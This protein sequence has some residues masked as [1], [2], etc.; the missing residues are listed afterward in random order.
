LNDDYFLFVLVKNHFTENGDHVTLIRADR[1]GILHDNFAQ[2]RY[3]NSQ[4]YSRYNHW[5]K[6]LSIHNRAMDTS[7]QT[8]GIRR[9]TDTSIGKHPVGTREEIDTRDTGS[10]QQ[11]LGDHDD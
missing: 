4:T 5:R 3:N 10:L 6:I 9:F 8:I 7:G 2:H 11:K 1:K